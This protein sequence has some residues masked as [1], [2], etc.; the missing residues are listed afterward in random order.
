MAR[1]RHVWEMTMHLSAKRVQPSSP[2]DH[3][4]A[5]EWNVK[6]SGQGTE[7]RKTHVPPSGC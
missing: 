3:E 7:Q 6:S 2:S 5:T 4:E 1:E